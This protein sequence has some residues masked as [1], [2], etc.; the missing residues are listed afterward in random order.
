MSYRHSSVDNWSA[1]Q[2][3]RFAEDHDCKCTSCKCYFRQNTYSKGIYYVFEID[4]ILA[5]QFGGSD[6]F[7][8]LQPLCPSC[9]RDKSQH[10]AIVKKPFCLKCKRFISRF[11]FKSHACSSAYKSAMR[12]HAA[13]NNYVYDSSLDTVI[14]QTHCVLAIES[15]KRQI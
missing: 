14:K 1:K 11:F 9:H 12:S 7:V 2:R 5:L 3:K 10:E 15:F 6:T 13:R 8:N 4:H